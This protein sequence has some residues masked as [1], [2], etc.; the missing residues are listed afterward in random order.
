VIIDVKERPVGTAGTL[1][2]VRF[3]DVYFDFDRDTLR[4]D[5]LLTLG[6]VATAMRGDPT[7]R[8]QIEG[9]ACDL[10]TA[11][12]NLGL[13]ERRAETVRN[14]FIAQGISPDRM[15][16]VGYGEERPQNDNSTEALRRLNRRAVMNATT[17][18]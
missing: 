10:G 13:S 8:L 5:A 9:H 2:G 12:Y 16:T 1:Q 4:Q 6:K 11:E 18:R 15:T 7:M 3:D 17:E 14:Y